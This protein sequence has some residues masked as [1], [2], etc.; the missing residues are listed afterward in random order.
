MISKKEHTWIFRFSLLIVLITTIP[1]CIGFWK[2]G[3]DWAFSG[4]VF[5]VEDGNSYIAK[6]L[7]GAN[8]DWLFQTPYT[9]YPQKGLLAFLPYILQGKLTA[10]PGQ[11]AQLVALFQ[12]FRWS[13]CILL[14]YSVYRFVALFTE[15]T[16]YRRLGTAMATIGGGIGWLYS[17]GFQGLWGNRLPLEFY[18]PEAFGFL[19]IF[20]IP[21][22]LF[23]RALLILGF[24]EYLHMA[25]PQNG[26]PYKTGILWLFMGFFQP[27]DIV[28]GWG[29]ILAFLSVFGISQ[30]LRKSW[31]RL[32]REKY[33]QTCL[34][35]I[36]IF[37]ISSPWIIYSLWSSYSNDFLI[38]WSK[39][40]IILSPPPLDYLLAYC[41][42]L[43]AMI[44]AF[45][46][47]IK[48]NDFK[49][50]LLV[51]W[52]ILSPILAYFPSNLQRRLTEGIWVV[53]IAFMV[54][55]LGE[56]K[57]LHKLSY[58]LYCSFVTPIILITGSIVSLWNP[59]VPLYRPTQEI[60]A[61]NY[62]QR[63][64]EKEDIVLASYQ[65]SN[66]LPAWV[67]IRTLLGHGPESVHLDTV[68]P[69]VSDFFRTSTSDEVRINLIRD[70]GVDYIFKG[71][72]E[73][74]LGSWD[75]SQAAYLKNIYSR[76]GYEIY[77]VTIK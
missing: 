30:V 56:I 10:Q 51:S 71:P 68:E 43:P 75:P 2:Q 66:V 54:I 53:L 74:S 64:S 25:Q 14:I 12:I 77:R 47:I 16:Q 36:W 22:L 7:S 6:M 23:S 50:Y 67:P 19:S 42:L 76:S 28:I 37:I 57:K 73:A 45:T 60:S 61:F 49:G 39:Q 41:L 21:H 29:V 35:S 33:R 17:I 13:G 34:S 70:F 65:V 11:H 8:G 5:G 72:E 40:N 4:F 55:G 3:S 44:V 27:L 26:I 1:Y 59:S 18:S 48:L 58:L 69:I 15:K 38:L 62:L 46:Y 52:I 63:V 31:T 9:A 20:G 24:V 32:E